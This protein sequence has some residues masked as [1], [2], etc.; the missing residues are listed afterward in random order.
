[1]TQTDCRLFRIVRNLRP[2]EDRARRVLTPGLGEG[3]GLERRVLQS[4]AN[5]SAAASPVILRQINPMNQPHAVQVSLI[6][7][8]TLTA[9]VLESGTVAPAVSFRVVDEYGRDQPSGILT[10]QPAMGITSTGPNMFFYAARIGLNRTR[11]PGDRNGRQYTIEFT[12]QDPQGRATLA[13]A[14]TTPPARGSHADHRSGP[15]P[16]N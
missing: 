14:V 2:R 4:I 16:V 8:V 13:V 3:L 1:M 5:P 6:R 7:P 15:D 11:R 10:P 9:S 12:F